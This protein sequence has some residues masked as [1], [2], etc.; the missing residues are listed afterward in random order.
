MA[1]NKKKPALFLDRDGVVNREQG[2]VTRVEEFVW[3][4]EIFDLAALARAAQY[5]LVIITNQGGIA[6]GLYTEAALTHIHT[7]LSD[8]FAQHGIAPP[9]IFYCPHHPKVGACLCR[10]PSTLLF[11]RA[12]ALYQLDAARSYMIGDRQRDLDPAQALGMT[13]IGLQ[14]DQA[15]SAQHIFADMQAILDFFR[16]QVFV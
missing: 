16:S 15:L 5:E 9:H 1:E 4:P 12:L 3:Q 8:G 11:E 2:Y 10:K 14:H 6:Q 7:M 13:T